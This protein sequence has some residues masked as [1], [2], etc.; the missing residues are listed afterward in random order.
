MSQ[1]YSTRSYQLHIVVVFL[2]FVVK[3]QFIEHNLQ[4]SDTT[5]KQQYT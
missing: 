1:P 3:K 2:L 4:R 5:T